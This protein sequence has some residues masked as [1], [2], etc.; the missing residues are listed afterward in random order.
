M[1]E[2]ITSQLSRQ[3]LLFH[4]LYSEK[5]SRR[6]RAL[7]MDAISQAEF[8][9]MAIVVEHGDIPMSELCDRAMMVKQQVTRLVTQLE[10]K[11][12]VQRQRSQLNRRVVIVSATDAARTLQQDVVQAVHGELTRIFSQLDEPALTEYLGAIKTINGILEQFPVGK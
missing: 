6:F 3:M 12:L 9:L 1:Q 8:L 10:E 2:D 4:R 7:H 11:G 5:I